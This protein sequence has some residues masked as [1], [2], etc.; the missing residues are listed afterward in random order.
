[1]NLAYGKFDPTQNPKPYVNWQP[2]FSAIEIDLIQFFKWKPNVQR[3]FRS[4][5]LKN[6]IKMIPRLSM[7]PVRESSEYADLFQIWDDVFKN[8]TLYYSLFSGRKDWDEELALSEIKKLPRD[9]KFYFEWGKDDHLPNT[10]F[11]TEFHAFE[12]W[13]LDPH[14]HAHELKKIKKQSVRF[15]LHGWCDD[16]WVRRY[17]VKLSL[18]ILKTIRSYQN[19]S[20]VLSYS[21][22]NEEAP[23]FQLKG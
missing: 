13:V 20:L 15:K 3:H 4:W 14:W 22:K 18:T 16:R 9:T 23:L 10:L 19:T 6:H 17:G 1:M 2:Q 12:G 21:G 7:R 8:E 11:L 5:T